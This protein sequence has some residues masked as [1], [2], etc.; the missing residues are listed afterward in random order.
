MLKATARARCCMA[1]PAISAAG[2]TRAQISGIP[3][4]LCGRGV[5]DDSAKFVQLSGRSSD[6][7]VG[8]VRRDR[9]LTRQM[10]EKNL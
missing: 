10:S 2:K 8:S 6:D 1:A 9:K 4:D 7:K 3:T 5:N